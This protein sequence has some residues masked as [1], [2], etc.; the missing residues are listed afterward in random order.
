TLAITDFRLRFFGS[1]LGYLWQLMQPLMLFGVLYTVFSLLLNFKGPERYYPVSLLLG[2]VMF[3][4]VNEA[5][6]GAVRSIVARENLVRKIEF[7]R[8]AVPLST[9]RMA[10]MNLGLNLIPVLVFL[11]A[12]G[13]PPRLSWLE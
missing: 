12:A 3:T 1:A 10:L 9:V 2:I 11:L 4:F 8:L 7:P 5:T 13:G 6:G